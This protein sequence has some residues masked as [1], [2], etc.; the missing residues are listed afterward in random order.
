M[1]SS[2]MRAGPCVSR[3]M[4]IQNASDSHQAALASVDADPH[5][6]PAVG[7]PR[8]PTPQPQHVLELDGLDQV[9]HGAAH[10]P[11]R[12]RLLEPHLAELVRADVL[13]VAG[14]GVELQP[15]LAVD[16]GDPQR[17]FDVEHV[18]VRVGHRHHRPLP[19]RLAGSCVGTHWCQIL[20]QPARMP[21]LRRRPSHPRYALV[22]W[23][24][25]S[26]AHGCGSSA[27]SAGSARPRWRRCWTSRRAT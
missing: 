3:L 4:L 24:K 7:R 19:D 12:V 6:T 27:A 18:R 11:Q 20:P 26:S 9:D 10:D 14:G 21:S 22:T 23:P 13:D 16:V 15:A 25:P 2:E 1:K 8:T 17:P 5:L